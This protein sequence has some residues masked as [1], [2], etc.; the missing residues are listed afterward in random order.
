[1]THSEI[2]DQRELNMLFFPAVLAVI[3][4]HSFLSTFAFASFERYLFHDAALTDFCDF[5]ELIKFLKAKIDLN[6]LRLTKKISKVIQHDI[7]Y[8]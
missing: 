8:V 5:C 7:C 6:T 2:E 1:M 4:N 3:T